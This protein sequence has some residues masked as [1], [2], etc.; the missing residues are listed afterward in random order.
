M[1]TT[2]K[3]DENT[4]TLAWLKIIGIVAAIASSSIGSYKAARS[5]AKSEAS[6]SYATMKEAVERLEQ[7]Q[8][9]MWDLMLS[10]N[11]R[12]VRAVRSSDEVEKSVSPLP[13]RQPLRPLPRTFDDMVNAPGSS[14]IA[15]VP[16]LKGLNP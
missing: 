9:M 13:P 12:S 14:N 11:L 7:N 2:G 5:N 15:N 3:D 1:T 4:K 10:L 8:K 16:V 6:A